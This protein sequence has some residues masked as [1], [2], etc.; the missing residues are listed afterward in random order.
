VKAYPKSEPRHCRICGQHLRNA[1]PSY[2]TICPKC[3]HG[4][5]AYR[6]V[7]AA[8]ESLRVARTVRP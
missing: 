6:H 8:I 3:Y 2:W 4:S 5:I 7:R 1:D